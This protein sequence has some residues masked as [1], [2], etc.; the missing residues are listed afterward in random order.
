MRVLRESL[1]DALA[2]R[3]L[4][5]HELDGNPGAG[6]VSRTHTGDSAARQQVMGVPPRTLHW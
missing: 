4:F 1:F 5:E 2:G 6:L 3:E